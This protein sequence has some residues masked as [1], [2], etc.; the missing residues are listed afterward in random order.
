MSEFNEGV[1][2]PCK[3]FSIVC[4][5][6]FVNLVQNM[7]CSTLCSSPRSYYLQT[8]A[9]TFIVLIIKMHFKQTYLSCLSVAVECNLAVLCVC[10]VM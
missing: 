6:T 10:G 2:F 5:I 3:C 7:Q 1:L 9:E 8:I 4:D